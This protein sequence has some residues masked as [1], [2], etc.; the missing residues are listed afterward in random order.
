MN[1][2]DDYDNI[3]PKNYTDILISYGNITFSNYTNN[4]EKNFNK[5]IPT[6]F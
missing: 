3:T 6:K 4:V 1:V 5:I 2:T